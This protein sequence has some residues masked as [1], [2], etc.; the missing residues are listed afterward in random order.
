MITRKAGYIF[1][2]IFK[3]YQEITN[4]LGFE[5][6]IREF[7]E[8]CYFEIHGISSIELSESFEQ[9][10]KETAVVFNII[11]RGSPTRASLFLCEIYINSKRKK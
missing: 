11:N 2:E 6:A 9:L 10:D 3:M 4:P 1:D 7:N 5:D 8:Y